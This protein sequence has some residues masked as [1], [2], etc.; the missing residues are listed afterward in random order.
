MK[1]IHAAILLVAL[2]PLV[3]VADDKWVGQAIYLKRNVQIKVEDQDA[4]QQVDF[5]QLDF[6]LFVFDA[7]PEMLRIEQ[8]WVPVG[9][10]LSLDEALDYYSDYLRQ[11]PDDVLGWRI[12]GTACARKETSNGPST[13]SLRPSGSIP[14]TWPPTRRAAA[15]LA[16]GDFDKAIDGY[17][18][19]IRLDPHSRRRVSRTW[20]GLGRQGAARSSHR[21]LRPLAGNHARGRDALYQRG[22]AWHSKGQRR[23][24]LD[25]Y[26]QAI[27]LGYGNPLA[28]FD[29]GVA[30]SEDGQY[31]KAI[32]DFDEAL[33]MGLD[34][35]DLHYRRGVAN[36]H[37]GYFASAIWDCTVAISLKPKQPN[38]YEGRGHAWL[39]AR[40]YAKA[41]QDFTR[42]IELD[43]QQPTYYG[44]R[45]V[46]YDA[47]GEYA[48]AIDDFSR[49]L[50]LDP[51]DGRAAGYRAG[52]RYSLKDYA[53]AIR[54][55]TEAVRLGD[56]SVDVYSNRG[57][58]HGALGQYDEAIADFDAA[59]QVE[60]KDPDP[61][62]ELAWL[63]A[64]CVK[65][66]YRDAAAAVRIATTACQLSDW[67]DAL[68]VNV[69]A[70]AYAESGDFGQAIH[71]Q[72]K[73]LAWLPSR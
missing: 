60:P 6:P 48:R 31:G 27:A 2:V 28:Y 32:E 18:D 3:A 44:N 58:A 54:D 13:I 1:R 20:P 50:Q 35:P 64:T 62:R 17:S 56:R 7:G 57:A 49:L 66:Q 10:A 34:Q 29:R 65:D 67:K 43:P 39:G 42:A 37:E 71:W 4:D 8:G 21:R 45:G 15:R 23:K 68:C 16:K 51:A 33:A 11:H 25:D 69:L 9:D 55:Y 22:R 53:G 30:A 72:E 59:I 63:R 26:D 70:A 14:R 36:C 12:R 5:A 38:Y 40:Q 61:R 24:A 41:I 52:A 73:A 19:V 46:A 47:Q